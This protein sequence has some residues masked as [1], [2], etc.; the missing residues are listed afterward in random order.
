[1]ASREIRDLAP[2]TQILYNR[3]FDLCRRD[4]DLLKHGIQVLL[5]CTKRTKEE[6]A[7]LYGLGITASKSCGC[8]HAGQ[9]GSTAFDVAVLRYGRIVDSGGAYWDQICTH[10]DSVGLSRGCS[11]F[12][13]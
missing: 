4:V 12:H 8:R 2:S 1:M 5:I 9:N 6:E 3:F 7:K 13:E 10:A 11:G